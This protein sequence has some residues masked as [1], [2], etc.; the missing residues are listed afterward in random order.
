MFHHFLVVVAIGSLVGAVDTHPPSIMA[1]ETARQLHVPNVSTTTGGETEHLAFWETHETLFQEAWKEWAMHNH[2]H[3]PDLVESNM[4]HPTLY[5]HVHNLWHES[6]VEHEEALQDDLWQEPI[7]GVFVCKDFL[8]PTS[9]VPLLRQHLQSAKTAGIPTRRPNGMNR[10]GLVL[11]DETPGGVSYPQLDDFIHDVLV[12]TYIRPLGR[13]FFKD[14]IGSDQDDGTQYAFTVHYQTPVL[15]HANRTTSDIK[16]KEHSDSSAITMN[17]NLNLPNN[18]NEDGEEV[19][20]GS[21][22]VF[23]DKDTGERQVLPPME[24]GMA[25][26]HRGLHRHQALPIEK[27]Q[28]H[29]LIVWL[30]GRDGYVRFV[31]Y[32]PD[33]QM[34]VKERWSKP[35]RRSFNNEQPYEEE[36]EEEK[37]PFCWNPETE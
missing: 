33:E 2:T 31:P 37:S 21:S 12:D 1:L 36:E 11:D 23:V 29:Q 7:P 10:D 26:I 9:G 30:F 25:V 5:Q 3:L 28:R 6:T 4:M 35:K 22:L 15:L 18:E 17:I 8:T 24:P 27:G 13:M 19:Y 16:L 14:S 20:D 34:T 32:E